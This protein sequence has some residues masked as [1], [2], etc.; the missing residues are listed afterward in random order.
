MVRI[1]TALRT[2]MFD[3]TPAE[4]MTDL[5]DHPAVV[6]AEFVTV[7]G[8][9]IRRDGKTRIT[10]AGHL[11]PILVEGGRV[12]VMETLADSALGIPSTKPYRQIERDLLAGSRLVMYTDGLV[13]RRRTS[14]DAGIDQLREVV[15]EC[16]ALD[17]EDMADLIFDRMLGPDAHDDVALMILELPAILR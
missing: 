10:S 3:R 8:V 6:S 2:L 12:E 9:S 15:T 1:R 17:L 11:P 5:A 13:E 4:A 16:A 7:L 14:L